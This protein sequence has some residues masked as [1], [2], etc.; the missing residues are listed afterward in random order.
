M[1]D[2][3]SHRIIEARPRGASRVELEPSRT[4]AQV[5]WL[6]SAAHAVDAVGNPLECA[7]VDEP[8]QGRPPHTRTVGL[9]AR[10]EAPLT[11]CDVED[12]T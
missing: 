8:H 7:A 3:G 5:I 6:A 9:L 12:P 4:Q 2:H 1:G 10:N 11:L